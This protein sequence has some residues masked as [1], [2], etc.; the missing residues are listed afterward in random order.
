MRVNVLGSIKYMI[1]LGREYV[2]MTGP[3]EAILSVEN[4]THV[5][6]VYKPVWTPSLGVYLSVTHKA[7]NYFD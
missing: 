4:I 6:H 2:D 5:H 1:K 3:G 7:G